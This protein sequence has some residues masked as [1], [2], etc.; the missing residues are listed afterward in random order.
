[1]DIRKANSSW[2]ITISY[3]GYV[4][5]GYVI[6]VGSYYLSSQTIKSGQITTQIIL[7]C[8]SHDTKPKFG[9]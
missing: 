8:A 5:G 6:F 1:V 7:F 4:R 9:N 3:F 2:L